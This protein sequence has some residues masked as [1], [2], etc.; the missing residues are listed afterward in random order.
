MNREREKLTIALERCSE[1]KE[2]LTKRL[3]VRGAQHCRVL[4][5][6]LYCL[7]EATRLRRRLS[8]LV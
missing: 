7:K 5:Q 8:Q 2:E 6:Y 3:R 1:Q 4:T